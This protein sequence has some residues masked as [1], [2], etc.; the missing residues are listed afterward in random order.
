MQQRI[1][2]LLAE[3]IAFAHRGAR[4]DAPENTLEAFQLALDLGVN[5]LESDVWLT[6]DGVPVLDHDGVVPRGWRKRSAIAEVL[7][8][9]LPAHIPS[10]AELFRQCG[11][12]FHLSLD[13]KDMRAGPA[14]IE[15]A[16]AASASMPERLWLCGP[17]W[18]A[19]QPL[20]GLGAKLVESTRLQR[21]DETPERRAATLAANGIDAINLPQTD[22]SGGLVSLFHRF[23]RVAFGWDLQEQHLLERCLRMGLDGV[24]SDHSA[25]MMAVY[26]DQVGPPT[27]VSGGD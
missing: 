7:R 16:R 12:G 24:F 13:L 4:A 3:P 1:P 10:L 18:E 22:W 23:E 15:V 25:R 20:R 21:I 17:S 5:G 6:A 19:L 9:D 27:P 8:A 26:H 2:S 11:T 14:V